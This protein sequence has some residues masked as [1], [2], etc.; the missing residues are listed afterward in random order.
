MTS[1]HEI[2]RRFIEVFLRE[3]FKKKCNKCYTLVWLP[4]RTVTKNI[5]Y[6]FSETRPLLGHFLKKVFG[7]I[8]ILDATLKS[9]VYWFWY[10]K[11]DQLYSHIVLV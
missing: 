3:A 10:F 4:P 6:F 9:E 1:A 11:S 7:L 5:M 8:L 2:W